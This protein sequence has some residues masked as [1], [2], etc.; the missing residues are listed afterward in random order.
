MIRCNACGM[1]SVLR[2]DRDKEVAGKT[3]ATAIATT[4]GS[5]DSGGHRDDVT[6]ELDVVQAVSRALAQLPDAD[7]QRRVLRWINDRFPASRSSGG[8][9]SAPKGPTGG[10]PEQD[11]L[12]DLFHPAGSTPT[13]HYEPILPVQPRR[14]SLTRGLV[15]RVQEVTLEW[16]A[17]TRQAGITISR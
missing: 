4:R 8:G 6:V 9:P 15:A 17:R 13:R 7:A 1:H 14:R 12:A 16:Q 3:D 5:V 10:S 11:N 2:G